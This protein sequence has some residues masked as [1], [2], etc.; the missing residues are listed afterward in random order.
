MSDEELRINIVE[1]VLIFH[2]E[3]GADSKRLREDFDL[4]YN[5]IKNKTYAKPTQEEYPSR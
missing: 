3:K 5:F 2:A 1:K 4:I